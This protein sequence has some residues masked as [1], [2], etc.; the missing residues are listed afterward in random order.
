MHV[1]LFFLYCCVK[2]VFMTSHVKHIFLLC[3][4]LK[5]FQVLL[6]VFRKKGRLPVLNGPMGVHG[7]GNSCA[8]PAAAGVHLVFEEYHLACLLWMFFHRCFI[9][10]SISGRKNVPTIRAGTLSAYGVCTGRMVKSEQFP[11]FQKGQK[12][13]IACE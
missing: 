10:Q 1:L 9:R 12:M 4:H 3:K 11:D 8:G 13:P 6:Y 2:C 7:H 5:V